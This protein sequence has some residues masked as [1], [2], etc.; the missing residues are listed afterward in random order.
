MID[1]ADRGA[2]AQMATDQPQL[3]RMTVQ[4]LAGRAQDI[5]VRGTVETVTP[6]APALIQLVGE[7]IEPG[8]PGQGRMKGGVEDSDVRHL[9]K[10]TARSAN[11]GRIHWVVQGR[12]R[13]ELL[14]LIDDIVI[15]HHCASVFLAAMHDTVSH[16]RHSVIFVSLAI[17][18]GIE[19]LHHRLEG[20]H[21]ARV[22]QT[23]LDTSARPA[24]LHQPGP[25][26]AN[27]LDA[28]ANMPAGIL[29]V[30]QAVFEGG[31]TAIQDQNPL[32][33]LAAQ[34]IW[35]VALLTELQGSNAT[36]RLTDLLHALADRHRHQLSS[37]LIGHD[38]GSE[39]RERDAHHSATRNGLNIEPQR[40]TTHE[41]HL[42]EGVSW[43]QHADRNA[44]AIPSG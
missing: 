41:R 36:R 11:A 34:R 38:T 5:G 20:F 10:E 8:M 18:G 31:R 35:R 17:M 29:S 12:Q 43:T 1:R 3:A 14:D 23:A 37:L 32:R 19:R 44:A 2:I 24:L 13:A 9:R 21:I 39:E 40:I 22:W 7:T 4:V 30:E 28:A 27:A 33:S 25:V 16:H 42:A 6:H 15:N 26:R